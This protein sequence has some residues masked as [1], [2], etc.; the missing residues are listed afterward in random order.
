MTT[1]KEIWL[2][3]PSS[4]INLYG[5]LYCFTVQQNLNVWSR[6]ISVG[7]FHIFGAPWLNATSPNHLWFE[8][9]YSKNISIRRPQTMLW[10]II[11]CKLCTFRRL[12]IHGLK[13]RSVGIPAP[14]DDVRLPI[15]TLA[16]WFLTDEWRAGEES[17]E[18]ERK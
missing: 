12:L 7:K 13:L 2:V 9:Q 15:R 3:E 5:N 1:F 17:Q 11:S 4:N 10:K 18:K 16:H 8:F 14:G 6:V